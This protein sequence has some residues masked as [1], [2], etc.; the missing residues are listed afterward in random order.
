[1]PTLRRIGA[2][3]VL[4]TAWLTLRVAVTLA[5]EPP[6]NA[7]DPTAPEP[8]PA[9]VWHPEPSAVAPAPEILGLAETLEA[10]WGVAVES[11]QRLEASQWNLSAASHSYAAARAER[12]PSVSLG[13]DVYALNEAPSAL[14]ALPPPFSGTNQI[15]LLDRDSAG[16]H[17]LAKQ[18]LYASGR[19]DGGINAAQES[20]AAQEAEVARVKLDVKL[21]VA[22][23]YI[24][25]LRA[26]RGVEVSDNRARSLGAH[27]QDVQRLFE[28]GIVPKN[29]LLAADVA[30]ADAQQ[31][32]LQARN[33]L[34]VA[35]ASYNRALGRSLTNPVHLAELRAGDA[36]GDVDQLTA[37][38]LEL[39]PELT[40]LAAQ[41]RGLREQATVAR[42]KNGPQ[43][44]V[45]GGYIYQSESHITP[46]GI[47]GVMLNVQWTAL[48]AGRADHQATALAHQAEATIR[49]R[50]DAET[51]VALEVRQRWLDQQTAG[52]RIAVTAK[53]I[54]QAEENLRSARSRYRAS[55]GTNTEVLDAETLRIQAYS[56][57][58][59]SLYE[60]VLAEMRLHRVVGDL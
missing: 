35:R 51:S 31:Q 29:D 47:T 14:M 15:A 34:D 23:F 42:S 32:L 38:A 28:R 26:Q 4:F 10:A 30:M 45:T 11:D 44:D 40:A 25:V 58:Y 33:S 18:P 39:R 8:R 6:P 37:K 57:F 19:I 56:N 17:A 49:T 20:M 16:F 1:M 48:D 12:L 2:L 41:A 21:G 7:G 24:L 55:A 13:A 5:D 59:N 9:P 46:N 53:A 27:A 36:I 43:V 3:A 22:E 54:Q 60:A 50:K 52:Q